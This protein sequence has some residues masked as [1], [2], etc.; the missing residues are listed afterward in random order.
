MTIVLLVADLALQPG[1]AARAELLGKDKF[2]HLTAFFALTVLARLGWPRL[3][4]V[5]TGTILFAYGGWIEIAQSSPSMG[6]TASGADLVADTIGILAGL[7]AAAYFG[8]VLMNS[9]R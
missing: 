1:V 4:A 7:A 9:G 3:P 5:I 8:R 2:E 6:R